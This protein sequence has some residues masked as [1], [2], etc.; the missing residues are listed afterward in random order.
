MSV[1]GVTLDGGETIQIEQR[2]DP[3]AFLGLS[4]KNGLLNLVTLNL[5]RF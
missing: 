3:G 4:L 2:A 5:Y 1:F